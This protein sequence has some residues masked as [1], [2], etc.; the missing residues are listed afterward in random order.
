MG[1]ALIGVSHKNKG[2]IILVILLFIFL[3]FINHEYKIC[4]I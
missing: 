3:M 2:S 4:I 1:Q